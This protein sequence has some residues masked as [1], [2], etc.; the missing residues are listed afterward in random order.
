MLRQD[1]MDGFLPAHT[2]VRDNLNS[3]ELVSNFHGSNSFFTSLGAGVFQ[4]VGDL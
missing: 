1:R 4:L 3:T 2:S